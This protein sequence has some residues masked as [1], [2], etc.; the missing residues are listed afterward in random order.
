MTK[1]VHQLAAIMF[2]DIKGFTK[3][4]GRDESSTIK[5][6]EN[7]INTQRS[8]IKQYGGKVIKELGD[9]LMTI[10][11][12]T[13]NSVKCAIDIQNVFSSNS[14]ITLSVGIH[15]GEV[16]LKKN[17]VYGNDV[18]IAAR[19]EDLAIGNSIII[20]EKVRNEIIN[21][22]IE[23]VKLG[24]FALR[25]VDDPVLLYAIY[26]SGLNIPTKGDLTKKA[27]IVRNKGIKLFLYPLTYL[28]I[29][30]FIWF[31]T[32]YLVNTYYYSPNWSGLVI[33]LLISLIPSVLFESISQGKKKTKQYVYSLNF[34]ISAIIVTIFATGKS[35]D[36]YANTVRIIDD[37]G[38][39]QLVHGI[40]ENYQ[41]R[42]GI[43]Y[44]D[45]LSNQDSTQWLSYS[46]K[47]LLGLKFSISDF[48]LV[49]FI[50]SEEGEDIHQIV[51]N[52]SN[53]GI[54]YFVQGS[55]DSD[56]DNFILDAKIY[57]TSAELVINRVLK[58]PDV[59]TLVD[60]F[61]ESLVEIA[62]PML[63]VKN[64]QNP[65]LSSVSTTSYQS[66]KYYYQSLSFSPNLPQSY[67]LLERS[68][69]LDS[70]F[71]APLRKLGQ[72]LYN[73]NSKYHLDKSTYFL[74][75]ALKQRARLGELG[76]LSLLMQYYTNV[77]FD[78]AIKLARKLIELYPAD[79]KKT[80]EVE[81]IFAMNDNYF[82]D[83]KK[84]M[85]SIY[86]QLEYDEKINFF[87]H[88]S[89]YA[90]I[91]VFDILKGEIIKDPFNED[92]LYCKAY[93]NYANA[94]ISGAI[95]TLEEIMLLSPS[96]KDSLTQLSKVLLNYNLLDVEGDYRSSRNTYVRGIRK[97]KNGIQYAIYSHL[98]NR[99]PVLIYDKYRIRQSA[100]SVDSLLYSEKGQLYGIFLNGPNLI[101][102]KNVE[103][104][105][106]IE[107]KIVSDSSSYLKLKNI[108][109]LISQY[110]DY[111]FLKNY[112]DHIEFVQNRKPI[113]SHLLG[114]YYVISRIYGFRDSIN[115]NIQ[116]VNNHLLLRSSLREGMDYLLAT[117]PNT[118]AS[119]NC[120]K[121]LGKYDAE[122]NE[123]TIELE[124]PLQ[125]SSRVWRKLKK[126][127]GT[128]N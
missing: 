108:D 78:N 43:D 12:S 64:N 40:K 87:Y 58:R 70:T 49:S 126:I 31:I 104:I 10:F 82:D 96:V 113:D 103:S 85:I 51:D 45:N 124:Y 122:L 76:Q 120:Y 8:L 79:R 80:K 15:S 84:Y 17:D 94:D 55:I 98:N 19:I 6:L 97:N 65:P 42:I 29:G 116:M 30:F 83:Y 77:D 33:L 72:I 18:N 90:D 117:S 67:D 46:F 25:N 125:N 47:E 13:I 48:I 109:N 41:I 66:L 128:D 26:N 3:L 127:P 22:G 56:K 24:E 102:F 32:N 86:D 9:G 101:S 105:N 75:L 119:I 16:L 14:D 121:C 81:R 107:N 63:P 38:K 61:S 20:S 39:D 62:E 53:A 69:E 89:F 57:N 110:P 4:M 74:E 2:T 93:Y 52:T 21:K 7:S 5:L 73:P 111:Y 114:N 50:Y 35:F 28:T 91:E 1:S 88:S 27:D 36:T 34:V 59:F 54:D 100:W 11:P 99:F 92:L 95:A 71:V 112:R 106:K 115:V 123:Y 44:L 60:E 118:F 68:L 37:N 23:V